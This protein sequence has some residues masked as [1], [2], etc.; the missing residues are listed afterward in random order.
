MANEVT[1]QAVLNK[2][3]KE[4]EARL[5]Q[6]AD[7][8][9]DLIT[10]AHA[11]GEIFYFNKG[12]TDFT[13]WDIK[14]LKKE[15]WLKLMHP[16]EV[17][18][19]EK[20]WM[21]AVKTGND[22]EMELRILD[23]YGNFKWH[24]SRAIPVKDES[25]K[26]IMWIGSNTEIQKIKEEEQRKEGFLKMASHELKTP[27]TAITVYTPLLLISLLARKEDLP[28]S[29]PIIPSLERI[30]NQISRLTKLISEMLDLSRIQESKL[31]LQ[32]ES[33]SLNKMVEESVD[34]IR[35]SSTIAKVKIIHKSQ[36]MVSGDKDRICQVLINLITNAIKYSPEVKNIEVKV[37]KEGEDIASVSVN[38]RG[39]GINLALL[40]I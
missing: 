40:H 21:R 30:D 12:W 33:F 39:I 1:R 8:V 16:E 6:M 20:N 29:I 37:F 36:L 4:S 3:I 25:R 27:M 19:V 13:G 32:M 31:E 26:T 23:K 14:K 18:E 2:T 17:H 35:Y 24:M 11:D 7:L 15:G 28:G 9:P 5:Q 38:D 10:N 22:F 34:D